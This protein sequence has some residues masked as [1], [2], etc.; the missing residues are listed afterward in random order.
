MKTVEGGTYEE[1]STF[2]RMTGATCGA[3]DQ[4]GKSRQLLDLHLPSILAV[5]KFRIA[6]TPSPC[7]F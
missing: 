5:S 6:Q 1:K 3:G 2:G 7:K 4:S